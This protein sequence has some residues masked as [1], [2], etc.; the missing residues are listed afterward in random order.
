MGAGIAQW[1]AQSGVQVELSDLNIQF[2]NTNLEKVHASWDK[3]ESKGKFTKE[4]TDKFKSSLKVVKNTALDKSADLVIEAI[5]ENLEVKKV[6]FKELDSKMEGHTIFASNTSSI[7]IG[8]MAEALSDT[9]ARKF[10][11]LHFFNPAT[12]MKLVEVIS[13]E[14]T[15]CLVAD[16]LFKW[17]ERKGKKPAHCKDRPGFIVNRV[18]RNFYG[19]SLR[20]AE[21]HDLEKIKEIDQVMKKVGNFKMGPFELLDLI[22]VDVNYAVTCS[23][24]NSFNKEPRFAPHS[25]QKQ[26]V[27]EGRH[28]KKTNKGFYDYE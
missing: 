23:V 19:E 10:L 3:L 4:Q 22:G 9:R 28:G 21:T 24:W 20:I 18:A 14:K 11:G 26:M 7:P 1:M 6:L 2:A 17:F 8:D 5:I 16:N 25:L 13:A 27:D 15:D 12:I